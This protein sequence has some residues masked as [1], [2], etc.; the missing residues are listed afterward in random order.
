MIAFDILPLQ[1]P[2]CFH[3]NYHNIG[4]YK[5]HRSVLLFHTISFMITRRIVFFWSK[6]TPKTFEVV[7]FLLWYFSAS[8]GGVSGVSMPRL[9]LL[10]ATLIVVGN[11]VSAPRTLLLDP[12]GSRLV[13]E[14]FKAN[15]T[16][17]WM[18]FKELVIFTGKFYSAIWTTFDSFVDSFSQKFKF[19]VRVTGLL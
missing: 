9:S 15:V 13:A 6:N 19:I 2:H 14:A 12:Q 18:G 10:Y 17:F 4:L 8:K 3:P 1:K 11:M 7:I 16:F 5:L